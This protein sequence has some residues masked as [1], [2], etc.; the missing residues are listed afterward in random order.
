MY[1]WGQYNQ[2]LNHIHTYWANVLFSGLENFMENII[3]CTIFVIRSLST[4]SHGWLILHCWICNWLLIQSLGV[5]SSH[6]QGTC[7]RKSNEFACWKNCV[8]SRSCPLRWS[9]LWVVTV[10]V[11]PTKDTKTW[12]VLGENSC[13]VSSGGE[14]SPV[15][16]NE[17]FDEK[18]R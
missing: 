12:S 3:L 5:H 18:E 16:W 4:L 13:Q 14:A 10:L 15:D 1:N 6:S 2:T 11:P 17:V 8:S 9:G 7:A